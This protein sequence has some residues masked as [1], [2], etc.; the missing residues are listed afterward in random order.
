MT[1]WTRARLQADLADLIQRR[2][3]IRTAL[4]SAA[5]NSEISSYTLQDPEGMQVVS[6]RDPVKLQ[7]LLD[8][9][10]SKIEALESRLAGGGIHIANMR[11]L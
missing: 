3:R 11:R 1:P 5:D 10:D 6:R 4:D 2:D 8:R 9:Y 7:E